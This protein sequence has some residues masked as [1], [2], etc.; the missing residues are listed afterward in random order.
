MTSVSY[1]LGRN[2]QGLKEPKTEDTQSGE[3]QE[4]TFTH[5]TMQLKRVEKPANFSTEDFKSIKSW[6]YHERK[7][8]I[9]L[10]HF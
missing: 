8:N 7:I 6:L 4:N 2:N 5:H 9:A 1:F 10:S 3:K